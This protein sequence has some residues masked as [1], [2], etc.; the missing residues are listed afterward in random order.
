MTLKA[1]CS[2]LIVGALIGACGPT[3]TASPSTPGQPPAV[4]LPEP[5]GANAA[6]GMPF[7]D[8]QG[9]EGS[10]MPPRQDCPPIAPDTQFTDSCRLAG[11]RVQRCGCESLCSGRVE[12]KFFDASGQVKPCQPVD[13]CAPPTASAA[14]QDAC[15]ERG[16]H[17]QECSCE[18]WL[19]SGDPTK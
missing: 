9:A 18:E 13:D 2:A 4:S 19:C 5:S 1:P 8:A 6:G 11:Y 14:F 10:C 12:R 7:Y 16:H 17:L 15:T 3:P